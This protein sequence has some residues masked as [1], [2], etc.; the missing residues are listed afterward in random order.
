MKNPNWI[1]KKMVL[2]AHELLLAE[3]G[4]QLGL[5][6]EGLLESALARPQ[7]LLAYGDPDLFDLTAAYVSGIVQ[8]HP[9]LDG[10]KR[11][12]FLVGFNFLYQNGKL[13]DA[14][15]SQAVQMMLDLSTKIIKEEEFA[16]W[17]R[18]N[19]KRLPKKKS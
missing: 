6:D 1:P 15:E 16:L 7:Q 18:Q 19:C 2:V 4:G 10:N 9:F 8:N 3:H 5:R 13:L 17:L 14:A 11:T 12:A